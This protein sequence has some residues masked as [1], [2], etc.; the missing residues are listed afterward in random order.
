MT[1]IDGKHFQRLP[2]HPRILLKHQR[3]DYNR[4]MAQFHAIWKEVGISKSHLV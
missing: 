3:I 4:T 1:L 2:I